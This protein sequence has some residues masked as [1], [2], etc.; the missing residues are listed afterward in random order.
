MGTLIVSSNLS[1]H[2][3]YKITLPVNG[4]LKSVSHVSSVYQPRKYFVL[5][6]SLLLLSNLASSKFATSVDFTFSA[7]GVSTSV[8]L[9]T[10]VTT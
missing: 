7:G 5:L 1:V 8:L 3:A 9:V 10:Y 2:P 4:P 6:V